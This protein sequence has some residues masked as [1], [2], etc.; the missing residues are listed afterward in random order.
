M[1]TRS[2][3]HLP[4]VEKCVWVWMRLD[5]CSDSPE[6][7]WSSRLETISKASIW[8]AEVSRLRTF[9]EI[10]TL[11]HA[12]LSE[13]AI[14]NFHLAYPMD[15]TLSLASL[16]QQ[17]T[18]FLS[19]YAFG[20]PVY[21]ARSEL[22]TRSSLHHPTSVQAFRVLYRNPFQEPGQAVSHH[23]VELIYVFDA[24][25][26]ALQQADAKACSSEHVDLVRAT[27]KHWIE[28][29]ARPEGQVIANDQVVLWSLD[30][31]TIVKNLEDPDMILRA[32]RFK[33]LESMGAQASALFSVLTSTKAC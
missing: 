2:A 15:D 9:E 6:N 29:I 28:F 16:D 13:S 14:A 3:N 30:G 4:V 1:A 12:N 7:R 27:Q 24:F 21:S 31:Q 25:H 22:E 8:D 26:E 17:V 19:D 5:L 11:L 23:C 20:H 33:I 10:S 32:Q 18:Q